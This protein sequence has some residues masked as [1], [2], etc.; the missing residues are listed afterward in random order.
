MNDVKTYLL[1]ELKQSDDKMNKLDDIQLNLIKFYFTTV[2]SLITVAI[3]MVNYGI[4]DRTDILVTWFLLFP[5][6]FLGL[7]SFLTLKKL[8]FEY[9]NLEHT[10]NQVGEFF[11]HGSV[12]NEYKVKQSPFKPFYSLISWIVFL[13][14]L[15]LIY[16]AIPFLRAVNFYVFFIILFVIF[17]VSIISTIAVVALNNARLKSRDARRISDIKQVQT[18]LELYYNDNDKYP[19]VD[20]W[21][22]LAREIRKKPTYMSSLPQ[23]PLGRD[24]YRYTYQSRDSGQDYL[25]R[26][27]LEEKGKKKFQASPLGII[28]VETS[29]QK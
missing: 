24:K 28:E 8:M 1:E 20:S 16:R 7:V 18:A 2:F 10:R 27:E 11:L 9:E 13:N 19:V 29:K 6:F 14:F 25:I 12:R 26:F 17:F 23:D 5:L 3:A 22:E 4:Y 21:K 15:F